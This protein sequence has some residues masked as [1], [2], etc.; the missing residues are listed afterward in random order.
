MSHP[1]SYI[2]LDRFYNIA[3]PFSSRPIITTQGMVYI[4]CFT[5]AGKIAEAPVSVA[6]IRPWLDNLAMLASLGYTSV[7][8]GRSTFCISQML[9]Y[10]S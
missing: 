6:Y 10:A 1:A 2:L 7:C 9:E 3:T 8:D 5:D 4:W